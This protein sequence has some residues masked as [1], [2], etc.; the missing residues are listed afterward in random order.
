MQLLTFE[1]LFLE[2][3][4]FGLHSN[5]L[6]WQECSGCV[7]GIKT[8]KWIRISANPTRSSPT[9]KILLGNNIPE[10]TLVSSTIH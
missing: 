3:V 6:C 1:L 2:L 7:Q 8:W 9:G 4:P 5:G 10:A